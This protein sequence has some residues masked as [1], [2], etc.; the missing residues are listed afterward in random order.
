[1]GEGNRVA[2]VTLFTLTKKPSPHAHFYKEAR[3][4]CSHS[5]GCDWLAGLTKAMVGLFHGVDELC[6]QIM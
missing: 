5:L 2:S 3:P 6:W 1:M 4:P